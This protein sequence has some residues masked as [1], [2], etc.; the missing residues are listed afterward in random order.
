MFERARR[1]MDT[2]KNTAFDLEQEKDST[3]AR[4]GKTRFGMGCLMARR[5]IDEGVKCVEVLMGG[6]DTHDDGF[7]RVSALNGQLDPA[8]AALI[9]DLKA[10]GKFDETLARLGR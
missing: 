8:S 5:L 9:D 10:S 6:W 2:P 4:Y 7:N 3:I 1:L